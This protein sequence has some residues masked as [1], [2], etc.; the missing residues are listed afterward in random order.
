MDRGCPEIARMPFPAHTRFCLPGAECAVRLQPALDGLPGAH[1]HGVALCRVLRIGLATSPFVG[2]SPPP[3]PGCMPCDCGSPCLCLRTG[4]LQTCSPPA[5][6]GRPPGLWQD[7]ALLSLPSPSRTVSGMV[8]M[9]GRGWWCMVLCR[10]SE[11]LQSVRALLLRCATSRPCGYSLRRPAGDCFA[12]STWAS[13]SPLWHPPFPLHPSP[14]S[15]PQELPERRVMDPTCSALCTVA[16]RRGQTRSDQPRRSRERH[17]GSPKSPT[18]SCRRS[19]VPERTT[20]QSACHCKG[21]CRSLRWPVPARQPMQKGSSSVQCPE[22]EVCRIQST[23][24]TPIVGRRRACHPQIN[25]L[26]SAGHFFAFHNRNKTRCETPPV[27]P[28]PQPCSACG[29]Q[30]APSG[31]GHT[32]NATQAH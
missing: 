20:W 22:P 23:R 10:G 1:E 29:V 16:P 18:R 11:G 17:V 19:A 31:A 12:H 25:D 32:L 26:L 7:G 27:K 5:V 2:Y 14:P 24:A 13:P 21:R 6:R 9:S 4:C 15:F 28:G 8:P 3:P 30:A